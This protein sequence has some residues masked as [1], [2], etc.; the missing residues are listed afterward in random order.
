MCIASVFLR[1]LEYYAG[2]LILTT[3]RVGEFDEAF[4]SRIHVSLYY[5]KLQE[6]ATTEIWKMNIRRVIHATDPPMDVDEE[7]IKDFYEEHWKDNEKRQSRR[8]NGR[9]IKNAFQTAIAL[10][11][12]EF[13]E[14]DGKSK[15]QR[16]HLWARHFRHVAKTSDHFDDYLLQMQLGEGAEPQSN[17]Y[18]FIAKRDNLRDDALPG[19]SYENS[20]RRRQSITPQRRR[21]VDVKSTN[22]TPKM[23]KL[24]LQLE[25]AAMEAEEEEKV[26]KMK[27]NEGKTNDEGGIFG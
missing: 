5:P 10:A 14:G 17:V 24:R 11:N 8:W 1:V 6:Y 15:L 19:I 27:E 21:S 4:R 23:R 20:S 16:P 25:I 18:S 26:G 7:G 3:N 12:W 22:E 2:V 13:Y 9:Q